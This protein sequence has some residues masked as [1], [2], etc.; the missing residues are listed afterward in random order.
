M[1]L[2]LVRH[3]LPHRIEESDGPADPELTEQGHRQADAVGEWLA[4]EEFDALYASPLRRAQQT[5]EHI[6]KRT[7]HEILTSEDIRE[8]DAGLNAYIPYEELKAARDEHW[9]AL[10]DD[11]LEDL[12]PEGATF[13]KRVSA[14]V[15]EIIAS[16]PGQRVIAVA[17]GG[18]INVALAEVLRLDRD[19]WVEVAYA[20]VSRVAA[21]RGGARS[22]VSVNETGHLRGLL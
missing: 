11:R 13:R 1:D 9:Q 7:G 22:I 17:H 16:H 20:S 8:Y 14:A 15:E 3:A 6:A 18:A 12:A 19:L 5:A 2:V 10:A 21:S 4:A